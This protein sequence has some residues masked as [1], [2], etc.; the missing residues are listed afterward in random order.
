[1]YY[2]DLLGERARLMPDK[3]ALVFV[4][5]GE[6]LSY[7]ELD[8][9]AEACASLW[10]QSWELDKGDRVALL[11]HNS[12]E[13]VVAFF[14]AGKAG[15]ILVPLSTRATVHEL[16]PILA[17]CEPRC[18]IYGPEF[19]DTVAE[20]R[21]RT[22]IEAWYPLEADDDDF[23]K[24]LA[25]HHGRRLE[26]MAKDPEDLWCLLYTSGTTGTPAIRQFQRM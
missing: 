15:I 10:R 14:A 11:A 18:L 12:I 19:G 20:L 22:A 24:L 26:P 4:P 8:A 9:R 25:A 16:V 7:A 5:T 17:N 1:M 23:A 13:L 2:P 21:E 6:R 3:E